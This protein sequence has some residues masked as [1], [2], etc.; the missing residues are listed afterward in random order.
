M[1]VTV[2]DVDGW[3]VERLVGLNTAVTE[4]APGRRLVKGPTATPPN[5]GTG[6]PRF[7]LPSLNWT[8][9]T[10]LLGAMCA[11]GIAK[12][13]N[14]KGSGTLITDSVVVVAFAPGAGNGDGL[15]LCDGFGLGDSDGDGLGLGLGDSDG[16]GLGLGDVE[17][18][19]S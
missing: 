16:D 4:C 3:N 12:P 5:T 1:N 10:D 13:P 14:P 19:V 6:P 2:F 18:P 15:G 11:M 8:V 9:P 17:D 7:V